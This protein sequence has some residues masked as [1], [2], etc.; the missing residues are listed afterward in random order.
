[1]VLRRLGGISGT[2]RDEKGEPLVDVPVRALTQIWIAGSRQWATGPVT[3]TDDRGNYRIPSLT[4]GTYVVHV[5]NVL[6]TVPP[7]TSAKTIAGWPPG[8]N[9]TPPPPR[10]LSL[11]RSWLT[12]GHYAVPPL[13]AGRHRAY[14]STY[15][16]SATT[17]SNALPIELGRGEEKTSIDVTLEPRLTARVAGHLV[18]PPSLFSGMVVRVLEGD[19]SD[20][21]GAE[22]ATALVDSD[23]SFELAAVPMGKYVLE[24][25]S[26][27]A[28][29]VATPGGVGSSLPATP[30]LF[31]GGHSTFRSA[32]LEVVLRTVGTPAGSYSGRVPLTVGDDDILNLSIEIKPASTIGGKIVG[33]DGRP[34]TGPLAVA[35]RPAN[36]DPALASQAADVDVRKRGDGTFSIGGLRPGDYVIDVLGEMIVKSIA[37]DGDYTSRPLS[38]AAGKDLNVTV[39][40]TNAAAMLSGSV[41]DPRGASVPQSAVVIF[42]ADRSQWERF[43]PAPSRIQ[44]T[45]AVGSGYQ[46]RRLPAGEYLVIAL[47]P[48][49]LDAWNDPSFFAAAAPLATRIALTWGTSLRQDLP[50]RQL[51]LR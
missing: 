21:S 27:V 12:V 16:P 29:W 35:V 41:H 49:M 6:S 32:G 10:G 2:I 46:L 25:G 40:V 47:A 13:L 18:G 1:V 11:G 30:G 8:W 37:A 17:L 44:A 51:K 39:T 14:P 34:F 42:P 38:V 31:G 26:A 20:Q 15:Y 36:G 3:R 4:D 23:G 43:G 24:A 7:A 19:G 45:V 22:Q 28:E 9:G 48:S 5:P 33:E 50:M